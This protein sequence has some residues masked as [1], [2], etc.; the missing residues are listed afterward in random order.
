MYVISV[1]VSGK[2]SGLDNLAFHCYD[3]LEGILRNF[4][5]IGCVIADREC[6]ALEIADGWGIPKF[7]I[8]PTGD[9]VEWSKQLFPST[10]EIDLYAMS[11]WLSKVQVPKWAENKILNIHPSLLPKHGGEGMYGRNVHEAVK[12]SGDNISGCTVH[13]VDN[14]LDHGEVLMQE[15]VAVLPWESVDQLEHA[16]KAREKLTYPRAILNYLKGNIKKLPSDAK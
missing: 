8:P 9:I 11:G 10:D 3:E 6:E 14:E 13:I 4:V 1:L 15:R 5:T 16:V 12:A 2:G 7:V